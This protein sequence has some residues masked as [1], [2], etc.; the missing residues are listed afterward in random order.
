M[1]GTLLWQGTRSPLIQGR[2]RQLRPL[3]Q[4]WLGAVALAAVASDAVTYLV[5]RAVP[6]EFFVVSS[7][8][9][10]LLG[11]WV[12]RRAGWRTAWVMGVV[13]GLGIDTMAFVA[14]SYWVSWAVFHVDKV[15]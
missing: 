8:L 1:K 3:W 5:F 13:V 10:A 2:S 12:A 11:V 14:V 15:G 4:P 7:A 6:V 9:G